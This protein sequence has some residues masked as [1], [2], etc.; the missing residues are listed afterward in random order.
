M[1]VYT[2]NFMTVAIYNRYPATLHSY[3]DARSQSCKHG[4][5]TINTIS[6]CGDVMIEQNYL[7]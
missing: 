3:E 1:S 6:P 7:K 2:D 4:R 5:P